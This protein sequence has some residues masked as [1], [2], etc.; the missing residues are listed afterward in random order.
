MKTPAS[1][2]AHVAELQETLAADR[3]R[4]SELIGALT[5][6]VASMLA[7]TR[8]SDADDEHD[9]EGSTITFERSKATALLAAARE[10][11]ADVDGALRRIA[12]GAYGRCERC[13][14]PIAVE[15]LHARPA[16]RTCITCAA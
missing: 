16:A 4:T 13:G 5:R 11:L 1:R 8:L 7:E 14:E 9:P 2:P 6:D 10:H 3:E 15:R 12:A